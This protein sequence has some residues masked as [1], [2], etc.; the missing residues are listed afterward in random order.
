MIEVTLHKLNGEQQEYS[1][2]KHKAISDYVT[3]SS[4]GHVAYVTADGKTLPKY[5]PVG[6]LPLNSGD[7]IFHKARRGPNSVLCGNFLIHLNGMN[8]NIYK[9]VS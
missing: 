8:N 5:I 6:L 7:E 9:V 4:S 2:A 3:E 1:L